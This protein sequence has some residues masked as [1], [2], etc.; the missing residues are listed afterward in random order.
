[1][2]SDYYWNVYCSIKDWIKLSDTKAGI[3]VAFYGVALTVTLPI[4]LDNYGRIRAD[5]ALEIMIM[6]SLAIATISFIYASSSLYPTL[7]I[8]KPDS[9]I[10]YHDI[11]VNEPCYDCY[12]EKVK[13]SF[14]GDE[15][16]N[17]LL[18]Q[19]WALSKIADWKY[20]RVQNSLITLFFAIIAIL[21]AIFYILI[22]GR[23]AT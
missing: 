9:L 1:M 12:I 20:Q 21:F 17:Q 2:D 19:I 14:V 5:A 6:V 4:I 13:T 10:F 11:A 7:D 18:A 8:K 22:S 16:V 15:P 3:I 23:I